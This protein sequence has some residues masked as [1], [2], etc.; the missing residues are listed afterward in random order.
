MSTSNKTKWKLTVKVLPSALPL[1]LLAGLSHS[2]FAQTAD[3]YT[4]C[5][6]EGDTCSFSG[7]R[8]VRYGA[9]SKYNYLIAAGSIACNNKTFGDPIYGTRKT[10]EFSNTAIGEPS[11][12]PTS[13]PTPLPTSAPTL[14]PTLTPTSAPTPAPT[15]APTSQPSEVPASDDI[16][17]QENAAG[18]CGADGSIDSNHN[19]F[20]G[21]GFA[22][23]QNA[24]GRTISWRVEVQE[25]STYM[26]EWR[27]ASGSSNSR[28]GSVSVN[29]SAE[30]SVEFPT[31]GAW[32]SWT[33]DGAIVELSA[34]VNE[35]VLTAETAEGLA[36][37]DSLTIAGSG[38]NPAD[39]D[40]Y[41]P[42]AEPTATPTAEPTATPT[43][44]PTATP[45]VEPTTTP[46]AEP[47]ATPT[48]EPTA[49]P[50]A[51]PTA[52]PTV[53]PTT[54]PSQELVAFPGAEGYGK[55]TTGG[56][57]GKVYEVTNLNDSGAGS[58]RAAIQASGARTIVFRVSGT[59]DLKSTLSISNSDI[60]IAGQTAPGD[61][62][63]LKRY[64]LVI[65]ADN[66][67]IRY[68]RSRFGDLLKNDADAISMR[69]QKN[70]IL[71]HVSASWG[72]D[73]TMSLYHGENVTI[74]WC[75]VS[76]T[77]N[78]GGDHGFA[79]IWGSPYS[80]HHHNLIAH[81]VSRSIRFAS[82]AGNVDYRNN[83]IYNWG[84]NSAY[85]GEQNQVGNDKFNFSN[86]NMV[87]N[88]YKPGPATSSG[89]SSR[90]I[91][92]T[93]RD[94][95]NDIGKFYVADNYVVG[96]SKVS[97]DNWD[98]GVQPAN[99]AAKLDEPWPSMPINQETAEEAYESVL[100]HV[101][102]SKSRDAVDAR[103]I[104]EVRT[105]TALY[106]KNG[107]IESQEEVGGWP[108]LNSTPAPQDSD[109]DGMPDEWELAEGL[110]P[111]NPNDRNDTDEI[112][113]TMLEN[114][115]NSID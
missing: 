27:Y 35:I 88:Y 29:G 54:P 80:T 60:T 94:G 40:I 90:I 95:D 105:G 91:N 46:S 9:N 110:D 65:K 108:A 28:M 20:T 47:T 115:L 18:F 79:G 48:V 78:R 52:T 31:T 107:I 112:G 102:A 64:P 85:G 11:P 104:E 77:L 87:A 58:L 39:C 36:N 59:I 98:G 73:E 24:K 75:L 3:N 109:H 41:V 81:N 43:A 111:S 57:G 19:G 96:N 42:T 26:L 49:T 72:D 76:E 55:Y 106:G 25:P 37:I 89:V 4:Y 84:Y 97:A 50:T 61:G 45:T 15:I 56:R 6:D 23:T 12:T 114:Y 2:S 51:E 5:A 1:V 113:Y 16:V 30:A 101:G 22:N 63:T 69:Y 10:C 33:I 66:V 62:I 70:I 74:Q 7:T 8:E 21:S 14:T 53:E 38:I 68:I 17:L 13:A 99:Q 71:D 67:I 92:P 44:E 32:A 83:V 86:I 103:I 34:G 82:G 93:T 100:A